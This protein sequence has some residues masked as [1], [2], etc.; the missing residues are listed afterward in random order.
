MM[1]YIYN[2]NALYISIYFKQNILIWQTKD[3]N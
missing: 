1:Q 2:G 3:N